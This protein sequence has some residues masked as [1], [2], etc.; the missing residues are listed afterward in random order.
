MV[1]VKAIACELPARLGLPFSRLHVPDIQAEVLDLSFPPGKQ[2]ICE[3]QQRQVDRSLIWT[4]QRERWAEIAK[5][6]H[7]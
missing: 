7:R 5:A 3:R 4:E 2:P 1:A 6:L